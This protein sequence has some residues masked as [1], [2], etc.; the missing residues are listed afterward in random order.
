MCS[1]TISLF[2]D[3][4]ACNCFAASVEPY[5]LGPS[6]ITLELFREWHFDRC[7][8]VDYGPDLFALRGNDRGRSA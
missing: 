6:D 4:H 7:N 5:V 8:E 3:A 1:Y 2:I